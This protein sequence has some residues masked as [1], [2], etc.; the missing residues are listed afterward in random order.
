MIL[1]RRLPDGALLAGRLTEVEAY[2]GDGS[3]PSSH[4][5]RGQTPRNRS[6]FGP[7]GRLY[8]YRCYGIHS[9]VNLVCEQEGTGAAVLL[10]AVEPLV[11]AERMRS[12]RR[13][14][15]EKPDPL[16]AVGPGRLAE[17]FAIGLDD[18]GRR[19]SAGEIS[20]LRPASGTPPG[21]V[22]TGKRIGISKAV[23]L[24]YRF[25]SSEAPWFTRQPGAR[26]S[27]RFRS[28]RSKSRSA[29]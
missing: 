12:L 21:E 16:I 26:A 29:S 11:G 14:S 19:L 8:V 2:L 28:S 3:D 20:L 9:C 4:S 13:L 5:H 27:L 23:D 18:D 25:H 7:P 24:P 6:M 1:A 22:E 15:P 10:R 17:A